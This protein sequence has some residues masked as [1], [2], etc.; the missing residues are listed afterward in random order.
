MKKFLYILLIVLLVSCDNIKTE[1][2]GFAFINTDCNTP[3]IECVLN[4]DAVRLIVDTGA[5]YSLI[6]QSYY[7][8]NFNNFKL[9]NRIETQFSGIGGVNTQISDI[10]GVYTSLGYITFVEQDL[11]AVTK[12]LSRYNVVGLVGSDFLKAHNFIVDY[13][14]RKIYP[15]EQLNSIYGKSCN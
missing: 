3:I 4:K 1:Q 7:Q 5:E 12:S 8:N 10:V 9:V 6:D 11:S 13:K 2:S 14:M 15:Y